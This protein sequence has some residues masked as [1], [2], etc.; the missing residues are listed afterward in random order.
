MFILEIAFGL[1]FP[2]TIVLVGAVK[3]GATGSRRVTRSAKKPRGRNL[4][5]YQ[6]NAAS[7]DDEYIPEN[8]DDYENSSDEEPMGDLVIDPAVVPPPVFAIPVVP[9]VGAQPD[10]HATCNEEKSV[11]RQSVFNYSF[12]SVSFVF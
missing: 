8:F 7:S 10:V 2:I 4:L 5:D 6:S 1:I 11:M 9:P 3:R 12:Y